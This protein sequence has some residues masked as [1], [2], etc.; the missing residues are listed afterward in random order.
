MVSAMFRR[1]AVLAIVLIPTLVLI[2]MLNSMPNESPRPQTQ[3]KENEVS[4]R[5]VELQERTKQ[6]EMLYHLRMEQ[7]KQ[8]QRKL[9]RN[10]TSSPVPGL[11]QFMDVSFAR[12]LDP[13]TPAFRRVSSRGTK[14]NATLVFG[15]PT[16]KRPLQSYLVATLTNL[17]NH[18]T[19]A[20][21][22]ESVIV[23]FIAETDLEYVRSEC[24]R[25]EEKFA[26]EIESGLLEVIS[27]PRQYYPDLEHLSATF[28]DKPERV[29][30][31]TK[32]NL[33]FAYLMNYCQDKGLYYMQLEDDIISRQGYVST[34][35]D[36][37]TRKTREQ[38]DWYLIEFC[39]LGFIGKLFKARDLKY[40]IFYFVMFREVKPC[41]WLIIDIANTK[42]CA[43][44]PKFD[45]K[46]AINKHWLKYDQ[47]L[48][49]HVGLHSSLKGKVQKLVDKSFNKAKQFVVHNDNPAAS[50][51]HSLRVYQPKHA[52]DKFYQEKS[53][54]FWA[55]EPRAGD[56]IEFTFRTPVKLKKVLIRSGNDHHPEDIF[57]ENTVVSIRTAGKLERV[58]NFDRT[59]MFTLSF[60]G[61]HEPV[62][63]VR[64]DCRTN[65]TKWIAISE[66]HFE[67]VS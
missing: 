46:K 47:S 33:D 30:W 6:L 67:K 42:Y 25:L 5:L 65:S 44:L 54:F 35:K 18:M 52:L 32:Q 60:K 22:Q 45:C 63:G 58:G 9:F 36:Y 37:V 51:N 2:T 57:D 34:I 4:N 29:K 49:Q 7:V 56:F 28:G 41:D 11:G 43:F 21:K 8:L 13:I 38:H 31:R 12:H 24:K 20:E 61:D 17:I 3:I 19:D 64:V 14:R 59:G 66:V 53:N 15:L 26:A 55:F 23:V 1:Y 39:S 10:D 27:P 62:G 16:V 40:F 50:L 48:F